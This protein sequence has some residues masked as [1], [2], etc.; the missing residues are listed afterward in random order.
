MFFFLD[1]IKPLG[2]F[3]PLIAPLLEQRHHFLLCIA[4]QILLVPFPD[5]RQCPDLV[6]GHRFSLDLLLLL[7]GF[8]LVELRDRGGLVRAYIAVGKLVGMFIG[9]LVGVIVG[10]L[11]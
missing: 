4:V 1:I 10:T 9:R 8:A 11:L 5:D 6:V 2:D 3:L 7:D